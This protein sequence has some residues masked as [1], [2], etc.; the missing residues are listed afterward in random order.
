MRTSRLNTPVN[1]HI[2][3]WFLEFNGKSI[4]FRIHMKRPRDPE[5]KETAG[6]I[7]KIIS[8]HAYPDRKHLDEQGITS[9]GFP[10]SAISDHNINDLLEKVKK[11]VYAAKDT[12]WEKVIL[13]VAKGRDTKLDEAKT[14]FSWTVAFRSKDGTLYRRSMEE[15]IISRRKS[16]IMRGY[17]TGDDA[18]AI[19]VH[20]YSEELEA[21][22]KDLDSRFDLFN[23]KLKGLIKDEKAIVASTSKL[24]P[25]TADE[26]DAIEDGLKEPVI[27]NGL[28][29]E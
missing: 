10:M 18:E 27:V 28:R 8:F 19:V 21:A 6:G 26:K 25:L 11:V 16:E 29:L 4:R 24:L 7:H 22:L 3:D 17:F 9:P 2:D 5:T 13:V 23:S 12:I 14:T 1:K 20:P 15:P